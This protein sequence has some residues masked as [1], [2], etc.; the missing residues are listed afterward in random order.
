MD[1]IETLTVGSMENT[2]T[3]ENTVQVTSS[4]LVTHY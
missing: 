2:L 3:D 4:Q 1:S